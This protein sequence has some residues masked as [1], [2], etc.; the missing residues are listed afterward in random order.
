MELGKVDSIRLLVRM[1]SLKFM[2]QAIKIVKL[3]LM[4]DLRQSMCAG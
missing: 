1:I 2:I 4:A 3:L